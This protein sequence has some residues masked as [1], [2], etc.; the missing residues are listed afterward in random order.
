MTPLYSHALGLRTNCQVMLSCYLLSCFQT[1]KSHYTSVV[2]NMDP[3][4]KTTKPAPLL[5]RSTSLS[6]APATT[7]K[8]P[9][10]SA[11]NLPEVKSKP[12]KTIEHAKEKTVVATVPVLE[13]TGTMEKSST[14]ITVAEK[15]LNTKTSPESRES[16]EAPGAE[17]VQMSNKDHPN[18]NNTELPSVL[19]EKP[20][21]LTRRGND[22]NYSQ[23]TT[24]SHS[25]RS[26]S[27]SPIRNIRSPSPPTSQNGV[28]SSALSDDLVKS[29]EV[30]QRPTS[31]SPI[32]AVSSDS[33]TGRLSASLADRLSPVPSASSSQHRHTNFENQSLKSRS[34]LSRRVAKSP[35][36]LQGR[37]G[38]PDRK[39][40]MSRSPK[41]N[42]SVLK[43]H[44]PKSGLSRPDFISRRPADKESRKSRSRSPSQRI[45]RQ[46]PRSPSSGH[47]HRPHTL[48]TR[49]RSVSP[50]AKES[51]KSKLP[52]G[53][54]GRRRSRSPRGDTRHAIRRKISRSPVGSNRHRSRSPGVYR[55]RSKSPCPRSDRSRSPGAY[56]DRSRSLRDKYQDSN[57]RNELSN[58]LSK[59]RSRSPLDWRRKNPS[60]KLRPR[61]LSP[62]SIDSLTFLVEKKWTAFYEKY[63]CT[64]MR[65][66]TLCLMLQKEYLQAYKGFF[67]DDPN[68]D[69]SYPVLMKPEALRTKLT[70]RIDRGSPGPTSS[71]LHS[72]RAAEALGN[73][74]TKYANLEPGELVDDEKR[75]ELRKLKWRQ[76]LANPPPV[77]VRSPPTLI[78]HQQPPQLFISD[79]VYNN[80]EL[81]S[82]SAADVKLNSTITN[83]PIR[84][85]NMAK[86]SASTSPNSQ[87]DSFHSF[88]KLKA[89]IREKLKIQTSEAKSAPIGSSI[90]V[91]DL[92]KQALEQINTDNAN[93]QHVNEFPTTST[94]EGGLVCTMFITV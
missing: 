6:S 32:V 10:L 50:G 40:R 43:G 9:K 37:C 27:W 82:T 55:R 21:K 53:D 76:E 28:N 1:V 80:N 44:L 29:G 66:E 2:A 61:P 56:R 81:P 84:A 38:T 25:R 68:F 75:K 74:L 49:R 13:N 88:D 57:R 67:V 8:T 20:A 83:P 64:P 86:S 70:E 65:D 42:S 31:T 85:P 46:R 92:V 15:S 39:K 4:K 58:R 78:C 16:S 90:E 3:V 34:P 35:S 72:P 33:F 30:S 94:S 93:Q 26:P 51:R 17:N 23:T 48:H 87:D 19:N 62:W 60:R 59:R 12:H 54:G 52:R 24:V 41:A 69:L 11:S 63:Y 18:V 45:S 91:P 77:P 89:L 47:G 7:V 5:K 36:R 14:K 22:T 71:D 73:S 79:N